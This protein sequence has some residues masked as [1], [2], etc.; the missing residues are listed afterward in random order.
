MQDS[1]NNSCR[2]I[3]GW[4]GDTQCRQSRNSET[5]WPQ[6]AVV[7]AC[8]EIDCVVVRSMLGC[9]V[10]WAVQ[11]FYRMDVLQLRRSRHEGQ[12]VQASAVSCSTLQ[13]GCCTACNTDKLL[14][15]VTGWVDCLWFFIASFI[16]LGLLQAEGVRLASCN[17]W[18]L[19][20]LTQ[21][22]LCC[23]SCQSSST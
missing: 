3:A 19:R 11:R 16:A 18:H 13:V 8:L 2:K 14:A 10:C 9:A 6:L 7:R 20:M 12:R 4:N 15:A 21:R 23:L 17:S 22:S 1:C 5:P